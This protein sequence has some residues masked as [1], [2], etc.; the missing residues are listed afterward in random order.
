M[1]IQ[2]LSYVYGLLV[3]DGN[4]YLQSGN[5]GRVSLEIMESDKDIVEKLYALIPHSNIS[6]RTRNTNFK[7]NYTSVSFTNSQ[8]SFRQLLINFGFPIANKTIDAA[9]PSSD[10][11]EQ[12][13]WRGIIDG[14]GSIGFIADGSPFISLVT[15]SEKLKKAFCLFLFEKLGIIK[16]INRNQRDG[17]FNITVKNEDAVELSKLLYGEAQLYLNRKYDKYCEIILW[18]R[19]SKKQSRQSWTQEEIDFIQTHSTK[20]SALVLNRTESSIKNKKY[21]ITK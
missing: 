16:N 1:N 10:Y 20:E 6:T 9:P 15:K 2:E 4:L 7:D 14:D 21:R 3:T 18:E 8:L 12:D 13:F 11:S 17:V 5:R 19:T